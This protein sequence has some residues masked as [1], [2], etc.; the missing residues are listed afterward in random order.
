MPDL[1]KPE[2]LRKK[3]EAIFPAP[4][5][6]TLYYTM[7]GGET[8]KGG[9]TIWIEQIDAIMQLITSYGL[10]ERIDHMKA[11]RGVVY[12]ISSDGTVAEVLIHLDALI[13]NDESLLNKRKEQ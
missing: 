12:G 6:I 2:E 10:S 7:N 13:E 1:N 9:R 3:V 8:H 4:D 5:N 11:L